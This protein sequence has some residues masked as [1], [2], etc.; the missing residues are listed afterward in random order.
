MPTHSAFNADTPEAEP[1]PPPPLLPPPPA[2][3]DTVADGQP[4]YTKF[5][6]HFAGS[7]ATRR[8]RLKSLVAVYGHASVRERTTSREGGGVPWKAP[9]RL[10]LRP[11]NAQPAPLRDHAHLNLWR[12]RRW[13]WSTIGAGEP[14]WMPP[15]PA[16]PSF[17]TGARHDS[18]PTKKN[19]FHVRACRWTGST[20]GWRTAS[21][22]RTGSPG[23]ASAGSPRR[24][25]SLNFMVR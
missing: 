23:H 11:P 18:I 19:S 20:P 16:S 14:R 10:Q 22:R 5:G 2:S 9:V 7:S 21:P 3:H 24:T 8:P 25:E 13:N 12:P 4:T 6:T 15:S 17:Q 1:P